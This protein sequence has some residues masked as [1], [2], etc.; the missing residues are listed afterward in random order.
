M[1]VIKGRKWTRLKDRTT[2]F[3]QELMGTATGHLK[4][5]LMQWS[6]YFSRTSIDLTTALLNFALMEW[7]RN[8]IVQWTLALK[9]P[10]TGQNQLEVL[11]IG[12]FTCKYIIRIRNKW[13]WYWGS[14]NTKC[15]ANE[16]ALYLTV[17]YTINFTPCDQDF[18]SEVTLL[19]KKYHIWKHKHG[20]PRSSS[21]ISVLRLDVNPKAACQSVQ[22]D[23]GIVSG[24]SVVLFILPEPS[25][26]WTQQAVNV[27]FT[28]VKIMHFA[29]FNII[30]LEYSSCTHFNPLKRSHFNT[31]ISV[32]TNPQV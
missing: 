23:T 15:F 9:L 17:I 19:T 12:D 29:T 7:L 14:L 3:S 6:L 31:C 24:I 2:A 8:N 10:T 28:Q 27:L 18:H 13:S 1:W 30:F 16:I 22:L 5:E 11:W 26:V 32:L 4:T 25:S 21:L 20:L